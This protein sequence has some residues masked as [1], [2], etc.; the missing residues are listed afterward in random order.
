MRIQT[1][2]MA[3]ALAGCGIETETDDIDTGETESEA[4][5]TQW[6]SFQQIYNTN[7][8]GQRSEWQVGLAGY[9]GRLYMVH[10]GD[11]NKHDLWQTTY[12]PGGWVN[13]SKIDGMYSTGGPSMT[14][15]NGSLKMVFRSHNS[16]QLKLSTFASG[17]YQPPV[18]IGSALGT[19]WL[20]SE[21]SATVFG[22]KLYVAYCTNGATR[23]DRQDG[24]TWTN[25]LRMPMSGCQDVELAVLP[26]TGQLHLV[27]ALTSGFMYETKTSNGYWWT[28]SQYLYKKTAQPISI[29]SCNGTTHMVHGGHDS[30]TQIYWSERRNGAWITDARVGQEASYGGAAVGCYP[31]PINQTVMVHNG[32]FFNQLYYSWFRQ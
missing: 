8:S 4:T 1:I 13:D 6:A 2:M 21:P 30:P 18:V 10:N 19:E 28:S 17:R 27:Y 11:S 3:V 24:A 32:T 15:H 9:A 5:V 7:G 23:V 31:G 26:D 12:G 16:N 20:Y 29:V 14:V 22:G 25:V